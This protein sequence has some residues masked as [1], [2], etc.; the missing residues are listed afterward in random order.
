LRQLPAATLAALWAALLGWGITQHRV[1]RLL[2]GLALALNIASFIA[3]GIDK[4]AAKARQPRIS[5]RTLHLLSL[6]GGW[7]AARLA[8][9]VLRHKTIKPGFQAMYWCTVCLHLMGLCG[10]LF[11][12]FSTNP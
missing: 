11:W 9:Q 3:Y 10:Y 1:P 6:A 8:Q 12:G 4:R 7:P 2:L 5:E